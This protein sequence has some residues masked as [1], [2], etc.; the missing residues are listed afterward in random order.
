MDTFLIIL[1]TFNMIIGMARGNTESALGWFCA[2][3]SF[4]MAIHK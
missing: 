4:I 3:L 2:L 1:F